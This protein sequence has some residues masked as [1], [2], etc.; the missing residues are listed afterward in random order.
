MAKI[1]NFDFDK[2]FIRSKNRSN[3]CAVKIKALYLQAVNELVSIAKK[4]NNLDLSDG[5]YFDLLDKMENEADS[6]L[7]SLYSNVYNSISGQIEIEWNMAN[8]MNDA[9]IHDIFK[10]SALR[11]AKKHYSRLFFR[12]VEAMDSFKKR[13]IKGMDLSDRVWRDVKNF[14][15]Q[16]ELSLSVSIG[17]GK[18]ATEIAK[19]CKKFLNEPNKLFRRIRDDEGLLHLSKRAKEYHPGTGVYRS[20]FQNSMRMARTETNMAYRSAD[21]E[22]WQ[23]L[24]FVVGQEI[25]LSNNHTTK[26]PNGKVV[27]LVDICDDLKGKYPKEFKFIGWHPNCRCVS[28]PILKSEIEMYREIEEDTTIKSDNEVSSMPKNFSSWFDENK[29]RFKNAKSMPYFV[30]ENMKLLKK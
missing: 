28:V 1:D 25:R 6:V 24:D 11:L 19:E 3:K 30:K 13:K 22:R 5:F 17:E 23:N 29:D 14:K 27:P 21:F 18:P 16:M 26:L 20:S 2:F 9:M 4:A 7:R 12:N 10:G 8:K 15:S